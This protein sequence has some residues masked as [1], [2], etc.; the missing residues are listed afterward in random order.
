MFFGLFAAS[1]AV[2]EMK[3]KN[4]VA[5]SHLH[6]AQLSFLIS[7]GCFHRGVAWA[8]VTIVP[9][10]RMSD[11]LLFSSAP[12]ASPFTFCRAWATA[13]GV[14]ACA[15]GL[16]RLAWPWRNLR[17]CARIAADNSQ[18]SHAEQTCL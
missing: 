11:Y 5:A 13:C 10:T 9:R 16:V 6:S 17:S 2:K 15:T 4:T 1:G 18:Y 12:Y 7:A 3:E 8:L 14:D